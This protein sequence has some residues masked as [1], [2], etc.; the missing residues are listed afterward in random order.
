M[1]VLMVQSK[2]KA[3]TVADVQAG[4]N[5]VLA[6]LDVAQSEGIR[7]VSSVLPDGETLSRCCRSTTAWKIH[8]QLS[9]VPGGP[10]NR[11]GL[12]CRAPQRSTADGHRLLPAVLRARAESPCADRHRAQAHRDAR[13]RDLLVRSDPG[14]S[15]G[16]G[17][18]PTRASRPRPAAA[19]RDSKD[20]K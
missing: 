4:I 10:G 1:S 13:P 8:S 19:A 16:P 2:I 7:Q 18:R 9:G 3:E 17:L 14:R 11:R 6:A 15:V 5:T 12:T 20:G